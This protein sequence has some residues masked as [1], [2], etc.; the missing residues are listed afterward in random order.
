M[1]A[2][3]PLN[4]NGFEKFNDPNG[5]IKCSNNSEF[6]GHGLKKAEPQQPLVAF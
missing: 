5:L 3:K 1:P 2:I 6:H 4:L